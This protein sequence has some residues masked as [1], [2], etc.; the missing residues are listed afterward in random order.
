VTDFETYTDFANRYRIGYPKGWQRQALS[1]VAMCFLSPREGPADMFAENVTIV[2]EQTPASVD[3]YVDTM[4]AQ[5]QA[6]PAVSIVG[7]G[8]MAA[9]GLQAR[10][11]EFNGQSGP[12]MIHGRLQTIPLRWFFACVAK[13]GRAY[14]LTYS[15][16]PPAYETYLPLVTQMIGTLELS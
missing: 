15:A 10:T 11:L 14:G 1:P 13:G 12:M 3:Q 8:Q 16:Q 5:L 9:A 4:V 7:Q 6:T 2:V